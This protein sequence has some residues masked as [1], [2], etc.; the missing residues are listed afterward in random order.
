MVL[1]LQ[2]HFFYTLFANQPVNLRLNIPTVDT[3]TNSTGGVD[4]C[5]GLF[6]LDDITFIETRGIIDKMKVTYSRNVYVII[7]CIIKGIKYIII[8]PLTKVMNIS[9]RTGLLLEC[10]KV[11]KI[12]PVFVKSSANEKADYRP[13]PLATIS[14]K[15][16]ETLLKT[17]LGRKL[18]LISLLS[19]A[20]SSREINGYVCELGHWVYIYGF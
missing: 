17:M 2:Y 16:F 5:G 15:I 9:I 19:G 20:L 12:I 14:S 13:I 10:L 8:V 18:E 4:F 11:T 7:I 6:L 1:A 3:S